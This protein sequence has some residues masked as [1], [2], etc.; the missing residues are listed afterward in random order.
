MTIQ[1][2]L[3]ADNHL[4]PPARAFGPRTYERKKDFLRC[5]EAAVNY[6][7]ENK[8]DL[9]LICGDLFNNIKPRNPTNAALMP[10]FKKLYD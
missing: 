9:F 10:H 5:F 2:L 7:L 4:D 1:I 8:P 6:A 3:T